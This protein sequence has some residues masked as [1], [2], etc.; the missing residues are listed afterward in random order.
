M[1][2]SSGPL[3]RLFSSAQCF[4]SHMPRVLACL[5]VCFRSSAPPRLAV[6]RWL[7]GSLFLISTV[8]LFG[9]PCT[10]PTYA[11]LCFVRIWPRLM[12]RNMTRHDMIQ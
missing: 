11:L 3:Y 5:F 6:F 8:R 1:C 2:T 9:T 12:N 7:V 4:L 10:T